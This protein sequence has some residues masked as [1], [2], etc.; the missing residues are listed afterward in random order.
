V[1][2]NRGSR[3]GAW[4][5]VLAAALLA[6]LTVPFSAPQ[7]AAASLREVS[8]FGPNPSGITMYVYVPDKLPPRPAV[9]VGVHWCH[10]N[11]LDFYNGTAYASLADK[12]GFIVIYPSAVSADGCWDVH[13]PATLTHNG[14]GDSRG[15]VSMVRYVQRHY[16]GDPRHTYV[17]GI[18]SGAMMTNVLLGAYPDVFRAGSAYAGVPFGCFAGED[19]WN[20]DCAEGRIDRTPR[21]WGDLVRAA[22]P[23]YHGPRPR[24]QLWHGT[25]DTVLNYA[26]F[27]EEIEQWTNVL[28]VSRKPTSVEHDSPRPTWTRI[29][30]GGDRVEAIREQGE[31]HNLQVLPE[32]TLRFFGIIR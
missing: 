18:S 13:S 25:E 16:H 23:G 1:K 19:S 22:D 20:T 11:A 12:Y 21:Q 4:P 24:M 15:I 29:R 31:P 2:G 6:W 17:T 3:V 14:G 10:G 8:D 32:E 30:Y 7:A 28:W 26:N 27:G 9:V 5:A